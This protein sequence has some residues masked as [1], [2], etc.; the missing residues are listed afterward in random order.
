MEIKERNYSGKNEFNCTKDGWVLIKNSELLVKV[1][2]PQGNQS[3]PLS[4][5]FPILNYTKR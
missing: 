2:I 4:G 1:E 3:L 5:T